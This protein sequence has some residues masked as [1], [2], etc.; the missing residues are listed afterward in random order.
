MQLVNSPDCCSP[1]IRIEDAV[2][3]IFAVFAGGTIVP[4]VSLSFLNRRALKQVCR[5][6]HELAELKPERLCPVCTHI[7]AQIQLRFAEAI[8]RTIAIPA[9]QYCKRLGCSCAACD[10]RTLDPHPLYQFDLARADRREIHL[11]PRCHELWL[12]ATG[13]DTR[14]KPDAD[15]G[16][17]DK[18]DTSSK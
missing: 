7:K 3:N 14:P 15:P 8:R 2:F 11:H 13:L 12:E 5:V 1:G 17:G 4:N 10:T 9:Q 16:Q 18:S 6:C